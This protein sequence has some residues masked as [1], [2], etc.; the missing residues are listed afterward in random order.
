MNNSKQ[1][2]A[3]E[4]IEFLLDDNS[5]V[6]IGALVSARNTDF[7]MT[8]IEMPSDG[9][10]TGY[11][12][13]DDSLVY[14]YSQDASVLG[15]SIGE[16]HAKKIAKVYEMAM[17]VGVPVVGFI[18]CA[19]MRLQEATDAL[20]AFGNLYALQTKASG[21]IPQLTA[22]FGTCGGGAALIPAMTDFTFMSKEGRLFV[23]TP[24]ALL[25]NEI[26]KC[27]T[28][29]AAYQAKAGLV[30][31]LCEDEQ[32]TIGKVRELL[33][34]LPSNNDDSALYDVCEDD[35]NRE[36]PALSGCMDTAYI[37]KDISDNYKFFEIKSEYAKEMV[38]GF[39]SLNGQT[40]GAVANRTE[41]LDENGEVSEKMDA[42]LTS[43]GAKKAA[44]FV[45]F[46]D[47]FN[48]PVLSMVN[49]EGYKATKHE[50]RTIARSCAYLTEAFADATVPKVSIIVDKAM[51]SAY[52]A[53]N[54]RHI[55]ADLVYA[56]PTSK[57]GMMD[58]EAAVKIIYA[59]EIKASENALSLI[60][61]KAAE[62]DA[63]QTSPAAA[64][65]RGYVDDIIEPAATR[66]RAIAAFEMLYTK[67][68]D[69]PFKKHGTL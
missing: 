37:L 28:A 44:D 48:I 14:V 32:E 20:D 6:E 3:R 57:I 54:S 64:A 10:V 19:G 12:T 61:E 13:V 26:S 18:D 2:S 45:R 17:K 39:I 9:V 62:Y 58:A 42:L 47:A 40:V 67:R 29:E 22:I 33:L 68:E 43:A 1:M 59:D 50:E 52:I 15:G 51:G 60:A 5:F 46:C 16:M 63:L 4:R 24:N 23:N 25:G 69:R 65:K 8:N 49:T 53:M 35:L 21:V 11:G 7:N 34:L 38:T 31:V 56:Y 55:G 30:D 66:K 41:I 27:D 36:N